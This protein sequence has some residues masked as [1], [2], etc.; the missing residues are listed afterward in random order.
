MILDAMLQFTGYPATV[1]PAVPGTNYDAPTTGA[2]VS[3]NILDLHMAGVPVLAAGQGARDLG[4]GDDP[5]LKMLVQV[6]QTFVGGTGLQIALQGAPDNG[7][8]APGTFANWWLSPT[9]T[10]AQLIAGARLYDMDVPRPPQG[11]PVPRFLRLSYANGGTFTAGMLGGW[12][13]LDRADQMYN[14]LD[15]SKLG[16]YPPGIAINN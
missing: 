2:Q 4:I 1:A 14:A 8:G 15:N 11:L 12:I 10:L 16:G 13:V 9:Y 7:A 3:S 5:A 6:V